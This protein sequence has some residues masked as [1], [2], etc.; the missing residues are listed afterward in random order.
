MSVT[1]AIKLNDDT[2]N[3][4]KALANLSNRSA[5]WVLREALQRYLTEEE[6]FEREK[7]EDIAEYNDYLL[8]GKALANKTVIAWLSELA[9]GKKIATI[10][11]I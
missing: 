10:V 8:T 7:A 6:R 1:Q 5:H 11:H 4:L 9:S 3:R 2:N